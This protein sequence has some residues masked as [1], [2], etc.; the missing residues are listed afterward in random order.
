MYNVVSRIEIGFKWVKPETQT[1]N[2]N[3]VQHTPCYVHVGLSLFCG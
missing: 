2:K 3:S 1:Q